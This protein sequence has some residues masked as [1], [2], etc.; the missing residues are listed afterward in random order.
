ML[1]MRYCDK[2][3]INRDNYGEVITFD[4]AIYGE[5]EES[6]EMI[7]EKGRRQRV[8]SSL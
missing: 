3:V 5:K 7:D 8:Q 1:W 4:L 6:E 2:A